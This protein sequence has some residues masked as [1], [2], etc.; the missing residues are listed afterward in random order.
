MKDNI[1]EELKLF[2]FLAHGHMA[3]QERMAIRIF[4]LSYRTTTPIFVNQTQKS[5]LRFI[6]N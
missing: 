6:K 1:Q 3:S 4:I 2:F 5:V